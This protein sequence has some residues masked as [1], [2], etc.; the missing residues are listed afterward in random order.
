MYHLPPIKG[1]RNSNWIFGACEHPKKLV[2]KKSKFDKIPVTHVFCGKVVPFYGYTLY[3]QYMNGWLICISD[4]NNHHFD[5]N[6]RSPLGNQEK[7]VLQKTEP[8]PSVSAGCAPSVAKSWVRRPNVPRQQSA[9]PWGEF[10]RSKFLGI[11]LITDPWILQNSNS[12]PQKKNNKKVSELRRNS[13]LGLNQN[14]YRNRYLCF[15]FCHLKIDLK[16]SSECCWLLPI[17]PELM[18]SYFQ[19]TTCWGLT[20]IHNNIFTDYGRCEAPCLPKTFLSRLVKYIMK[21]QMDSIKNRMGP[22][23]THP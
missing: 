23:P 8:K 14:V 13:T 16:R 3:N 10:V 6:L 1:T 7:E 2:K 12:L 19:Q 20:Q 17:Q 18:N 5:V 9:I 4:P 11:N 21:I 22:Y 15:F